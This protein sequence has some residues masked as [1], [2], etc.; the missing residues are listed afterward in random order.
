LVHAAA[1]SPQVAEVGRNASLQAAELPLQWSFASSLQASPLTE[2]VQRTDDA[3]NPLS[4]QPPLPL[5]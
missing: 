4:V 1:A 5:Q 3:L 2:P